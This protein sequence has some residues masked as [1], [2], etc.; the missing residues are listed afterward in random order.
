MAATFAADDPFQALAATGGV[1]IFIY[2]VL[3][4]AIVASN[5]ILFTKAGQPGWAA[6]IPIYNIVVLLQI[7]GK[8]VWWVVLAIIPCVNLSWIVL[9]FIVAIA[10]AERFGKGVGFGIGLALLPFV[11]YP[12]L[13]FSDARYTPPPPEGGQRRY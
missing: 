13:A 10:L 2:V 4:V 6:I 3:I 9:G 11:F 5:W 7:T 12:L 1:V 8:P